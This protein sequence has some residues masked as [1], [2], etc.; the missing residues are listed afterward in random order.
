[1]RVTYM[2]SASFNQNPS[3]AKKEA[4]ERPVVIT[5]HGEAS[6][7]LL[8]YSEFEANWNKPRTLYEALRDPDAPKTKEFDPERIEFDR[9]TPKF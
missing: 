5:D 6:Y 7:V 2:T 8:R 9:R 1:M 3:R 4:N